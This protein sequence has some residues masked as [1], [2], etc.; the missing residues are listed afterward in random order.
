MRYYKQRNGEWVRPI[1]DYRF[2]CCDCGL[3]HRAEFRV[4]NGHIE[5]RCW[6]DNKSTKERRKQKA[7]KRMDK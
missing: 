7:T 5:W 3:V 4:T 2:T 6:R 1:K